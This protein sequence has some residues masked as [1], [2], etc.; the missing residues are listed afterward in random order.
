MAPKAEVEGTENSSIVSLAATDSI[1]STS[2]ASLAVTGQTKGP[3][4]D[5]MGEV[6]ETNSSKS[7][8]DWQTVHNSIH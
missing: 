8:L 3:N 2:M 4:I 6:V 1:K 5:A 7:E